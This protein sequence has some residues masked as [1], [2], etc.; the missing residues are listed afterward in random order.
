MSYHICLKP[1]LLLMAL[2][3]VHLVATSQQQTGLSSYTQAHQLYTAYEARHGNYIQTPNIRLHYLSWGDRKNPA[4][5]WLHGS[6]TNAYEL[7]SIAPQLADAGYFVI[8][9]DYYGHGQ[10]PIPAH[11]V[12]LYHAADDVHFLLNELNI[13]KA[14]IGGFSR[15]AYIA[16]AFYDS[17]PSSVRG[18]ILEE[19]GTVA[20]NSYFHRLSDATL[21]SLIQKQ[22]A[23]SS[24]SNPYLQEFD[25]Q[26]AA[27][28]FLK[29]STDQ[30][31]QFELLSWISRNKQDKW[32]I[33]K[34]LE[35][36]LGLSTAE[37]F[38]NIVL[39]PSKSPMFARSITSI[40]P[41]I[42]YRNLSVPVL[43]MEACSDTDPLPFDEENRI[44]TKQFKPWVI[45]KRYPGIEHNIHFEQPKLFTK[46]IIEFL[47]QHY[48]DDQRSTGDH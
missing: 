23:L 4:V 40:D 28:D 20:F 36:F 11:E 6:L 18:L 16:T 26:Q 25:S 15:G 37:D 34:D 41:M 30:S 32:I 38:K 22:T 13:S 24:Q 44:F 3:S 10:T 7:M 43:L 14:Y 35:P 9:M 39:R 46:D 19:G 1:L 8:A 29:D 45:H 21:D 17:Y 47:N 2:I 42:I 33:Y 12:S 48:H 27:F 5:V 31:P